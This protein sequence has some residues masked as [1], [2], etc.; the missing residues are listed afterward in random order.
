MTPWSDIII[1][2]LIGLGFIVAAYF[3][4]KSFGDWVDDQDDMDR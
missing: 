4:I 1:G 3:G 2:G